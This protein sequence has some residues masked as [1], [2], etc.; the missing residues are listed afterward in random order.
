MGIDAATTGAIEAMSLY[1]DESVDA[2]KRVQP[3]EEIVPEIILEA[4]RILGHVSQPARDD[5][6]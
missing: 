4:E 2:V 6:P 1:A 3:A 5:L